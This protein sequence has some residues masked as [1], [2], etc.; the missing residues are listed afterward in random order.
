M[1]LAGDTNDTVRRTGVN[2]GPHPT[3]PQTM[4]SMTRPQPELV[5]PWVAD[6]RKTRVAD[7]GGQSS[8]WCAGARP[9]GAGCGTS[10]AR[11]PQTVH[12]AVKPTV[13]PH[14]DYSSDPCAGRPMEIP[15]A[16]EVSRRAQTSAEVVCNSGD[17]TTSTRRS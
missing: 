12:V 11:W 5:E 3:L 13:Q 9:D 10:I 17:R 2:Q 8:A 14:S 15:G 16:P 1:P 4:A 7:V 6:G